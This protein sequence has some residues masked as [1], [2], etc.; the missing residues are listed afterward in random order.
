MQLHVV[1]WHTSCSSP[2]ESVSH[3]SFCQFVCACSSCV[4]MHSQRL[5]LKK[6]YESSLVSTL[7]FFTFSRKRPRN[8]YDCMSCEVHSFSYVNFAEYSG[9]VC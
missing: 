4:H 5:A 9:T 3:H 7:G 6:G 2:E 1:I 8:S